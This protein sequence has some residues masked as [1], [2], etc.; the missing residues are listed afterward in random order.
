MK[1]RSTSQTKWLAKQPASQRTHSQIK[2]VA[3]QVRIPLS[4]LEFRKSILLFPKFAQTQV[5]VKTHPRA[6]EN[7][8][9]L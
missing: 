3:P 7:K 4:I 5:F 1:E 8:I 6:Q 2:Y 9:P